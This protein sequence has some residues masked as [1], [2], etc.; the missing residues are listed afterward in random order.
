MSDAL[1]RRGCGTLTSDDAGQRVRLQAWVHRRRDLGGLIFLN[2]RDRSGNAQVVVRP[3]ESAEAAA[4]LSEVRQEWVV[5]VEGEVARRAPEAVNPD[6]ATGAVEVVAREVT[7]LNACRPLP[8]QVAE[9]ENGGAVTDH[10]HHVAFAGVGIS[11]RGV[12]GDLAAGFCY[13]GAVGQ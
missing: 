8:F 7:I 5:E 2:L 1:K 10:R 12:S 9:A 13:A 6:M 4:V 3:D 11:G